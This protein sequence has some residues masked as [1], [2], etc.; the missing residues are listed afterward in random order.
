M[1]GS[2]FCVSY[3]R[4]E[5]VKVVHEIGQGVMIDNGAFSAW[6]NG[7]QPDWPGYYRFCEKW[8]EHW[9]T[10]AVIP[11][12]IEGDV[13]DNDE[14]VA[15]WPFGGRGAPVWH[16]HEPLGRLER[17]VEEWPLV[18]F[19]SS[20]EY[21]S[22]GDERWSRRMWRA[23]DVACD[24]DGVPKT[25]LHMLRGLRFSGGLYPFYSADSTNVARNHKRQN[26]LGEDI[27]SLTR[28]IDALQTPA[29]WSR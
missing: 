20:G 26:G 11:D 1:A 12:S 9:T 28:R 10:W 29:R 4:P 21:S 18:C 14:L 3:A 25:P 8:L 23:M 2:F 13:A 24:E 19:G 16:L 15:Q 5:D 17:L 27:F 7:F 22:P 6:R